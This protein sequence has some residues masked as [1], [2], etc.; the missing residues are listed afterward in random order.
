[1][2]NASSW[3]WFLSCLSAAL[4]ASAIRLLSKWSSDPFKAEVIPHHKWVPDN[5]LTDS[6]PGSADPVN[7]ILSRS[8]TRNATLM[9]N[10]LWPFSLKHNFEWWTIIQTWFLPPPSYSF[11][12]FTNS[13]QFLVS[14]LKW[15]CHLCICSFSSPR[16]SQTSANYCPKLLAW[17]VLQRGIS[18]F[19]SVEIWGLFNLYA[20]G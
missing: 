4:R 3:S 16:F 10:L 12:K 7:H 11:L 18:P 8:H 2:C 19:C 17:R 20:S 13:A 6:Y 9:S 15:V 1:M 5:I 14:A